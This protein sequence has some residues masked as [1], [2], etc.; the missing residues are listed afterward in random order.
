MFKFTNTLSNTAT[1]VLG[2][3]PMLAL[4]GAAHA[5]PMTLKV[6]NLDSAQGVRAFEQSV[7]AVA[8]DM[9]RSQPLVGTRI[10]NDAACIAAVRAEVAEKL[11]STQR[12]QIAQA[13][14]AVLAAR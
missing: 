6:S 7:D 8:Q 12:Q 1:L 4:A 11:T 13:G 9:C 2:A 10:R 5:A 14:G 3:L